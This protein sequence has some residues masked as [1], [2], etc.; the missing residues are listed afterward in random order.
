VLLKHGFPN[1]KPTPA[2]RAAAQHQLAAAGFIGS[3]YLQ[4]NQETA[5]GVGAANEDNGKEKGSGGAAKV[6]GGED[7]SNFTVREGKNSC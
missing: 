5:S 2:I 3:R 1:G 6:N 4:H 7:V